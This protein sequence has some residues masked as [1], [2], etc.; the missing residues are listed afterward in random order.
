MYVCVCQ[1]VPGSIFD[2]RI[3]YACSDA[4]GFFVDRCLCVRG[5]DIVRLYSSLW[6]FVRVRVYTCI[7]VCARVWGYVLCVCEYVCICVC[8]LVC[9]HVCLYVFLYVCKCAYVCVYGYVCIYV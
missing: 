4:F 7:C 2:R 6:H 9:V 3:K 5:C 8:M 1:Y